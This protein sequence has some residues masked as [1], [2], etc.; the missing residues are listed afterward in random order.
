MV[1]WVE[2]KIDGMYQVDSQHHRK[3][4]SYFHGKY[5]KKS[6]AGRQSDD[7]SV[8]DDTA[9]CCSESDVSI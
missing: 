7:R 8:P 5:I 9:Q 4:Y 2:L 6:A 3:H 1:E